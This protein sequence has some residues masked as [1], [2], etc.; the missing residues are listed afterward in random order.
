MHSIGLMYGYIG[1][2]LHS[3][4]A[5]ASAEG[6]AR[7]AATNT[8]LLQSQVDRLALAVEALWT[9]VQDTTG[10]TDEQLMERITEVDMKDG[11]RD[12]RVKRPARDCPK[13][14]RKIPPRSPRCIYC[15][16]DV[17]YVPFQ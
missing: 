13:C 5:A 7:D 14:K 16:T 15:G 8:L 2:D 1:R 4:A 10:A 11:R 17:H 3:G 6:A 12:G 9:I